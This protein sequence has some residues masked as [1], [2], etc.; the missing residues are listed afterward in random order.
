[1]A[2]DNTILLNISAKATG[3]ESVKNNVN[4]INDSVDNYKETIKDL[5]IPLLR[6]MLSL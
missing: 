1:M 5:W 3:F 6:R 4:N 2:K